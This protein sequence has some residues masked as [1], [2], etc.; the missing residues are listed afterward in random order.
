MSITNSVAAPYGLLLMYAMDMY[1]GLPEPRII[2]TPPVDPRV[3]AAGWTIVAYVTGQDAIL[4]PKGQLGGGDRVYYGFLAQNNTDP[5]QFVAVV[6]GTNGFVEWVEDAEF[7]PVPWPRDRTA[8]VE[9]GF[10]GI[11][12][13]MTLVRPSGAPIGNKVAD[14]VTQMVQGAKVM[15]IG[16]SLGSALAT[17]LSLDLAK[18]PI[19]NRVSACLFASPQTGD[20]ALTTKYDATVNDYRVFNYILD[21]VPRVPL[22]LGYQT[23]PRTTVLQPSTAEASIKVDILC[24]HHVISYVSMLD[25]E[26]SQATGVV[27]TNDDKQ[28][29][30]CILGPETAGPTMAKLL[31]RLSGLI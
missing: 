21:L 9:Q 29:A 22:G 18:G 14:G 23:L 1:T 16:H 28:C 12:D 3:T 13:S 24:N 8:T 27:V 19:G 26:A 31:A 2:V 6:R 30:A 17:Y 15:V 11:Y 5:T 10:W 4:P 7:V 25:F 20:A